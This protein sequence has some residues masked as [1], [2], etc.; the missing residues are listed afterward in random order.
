[1]G[2]IEQTHANT[3][4]DLKEDQKA[5]HD[6]RIKAREADHFVN[7]KDGQWEPDIIQMYTNKPRYTIDLTSGIIADVSGEMNSMDFDI[8]VSPAG[9]EATTDI[10][11]H[12]DGLIRNIENNSTPK[13]KYIYRAA[14]KQMLTTGLGGWGIKAGYRSPL[15]FDQDL[16]LYPISNFMDRVWFDANA[17][18]QDMSDASRGWKL[19]NMSMEAYKKQFPEGSGMSIAN[20]REMNVYEHKKSHSVTVAQRYYKKEESINL[21]RMSNGAVY[22]DDEKFQ[23]VKDELALKGVTVDR[24]RTTIAHRVYQQMIDGADILG[25]PE[26]TVFSYIPLIPCYGNFEISEDKVIYW[27]LVEKHMDPQRILNYAESRKIG[28][29]ALAPRAKKWMTP[30]QAAGHQKTLRTMNTNDD[31]IQFYNHVDTQPPPYETGGA[32]INPGLKETTESM[33]GYMQTISGRMDPSRQGSAGLQS[34]V[35]LQALQ[36]KGDNANYGYFVSMEIAIAH[37]C[38][39]LQDAIPRVYDAQREV[40]LDSQD[41]TSKTITIN[42]RVYDQ[43]TQQVVDLNDL[44][45]GEYLV[46]CEAGPAFHNRQ[47]ETISAINEVAAIDPTIMQT[48]GDIYLANIPAP[49]MDK[50]A[51]RKR[52]QMLQQGLIP[53]EEMTDEEREQMQAAQAQPQ[54]PSAM[55]QALIATAQAEAEK[56]QAQTADTMSKITEREQKIELQANKMLMEDQNKKEDRML[57]MMKEQNNQI[58]TLADTLKTLKDAIGAEAIVTPANTEAYNKQAVK[59]I[60]AIEDSM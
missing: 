24:T 34:G 44:S 22:I 5:D 15:S 30:Q 47:Q 18:L 46:T 23:M 10:A 13:A 21:L 42:Q 31:P 53:E 8:K 55:D 49:G 57:D 26:E 29:G 36:N 38:K 43:Q 20:D 51:K 9:G 27:G 45:K 41:G 54:E 60:E 59:T 2:T 52:A 3:L 6:G 4:Q 14:G 7:K 12:Y 11:L 56:A 19:T 28:E 16:M 40:Q 58:K 17:E 1:M 33:N 48:G 32:Q 50:I 35:A 25:D 39:I 37:T